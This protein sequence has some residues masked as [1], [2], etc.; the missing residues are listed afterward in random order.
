METILYVCLRWDPLLAAYIRI[1]P[2]GFSWNQ[3]Q[4][5]YDLL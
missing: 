2:T 4:L 5:T 3:R 1:R